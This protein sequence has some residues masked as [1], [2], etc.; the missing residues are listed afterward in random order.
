MKDDRREM[1]SHLYEPPPPA[2]N[3][4][5]ALTAAV[6]WGAL[7]ILAGVELYLAFILVPG[8]GQ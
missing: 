3:I 4:G 1:P 6:L 7:A 5:T 2:D 8:T